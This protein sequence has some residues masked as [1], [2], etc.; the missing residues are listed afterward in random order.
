MVRRSLG[1]D[2][3]PALAPPGGTGV[4]TGQALLGA[5][6]A[7]PAVAT[8]LVAQRPVLL[9]PFGLTRRTGSAA[10]GGSGRLDLTDALLLDFDSLL[11]GGEGGLD[12]VEVLGAAVAAL[13]ERREQQPVNGP[14]QHQRHLRLE[15]VVRERT[16][17]VDEGLTTLL[18]LQLQFALLADLLA[19]CRQLLEDLLDDARPSVDPVPDE[20][21]EAAALER[22]DGPQAVQLL[23]EE[24]KDERIHRSHR[25]CDDAQLL[26]RTLERTEVVLTG[27][28]TLTACRAHHGDELRRHLGLVADGLQ[29]VDDLLKHRHALVDRVIAGGGGHGFLSPVIGWAPMARTNS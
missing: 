19:E 24:L 11:E 5:V 25:V 4:A 26:E 10:L 21:V 12:V 15:R 29:Q 16:K 17:P 20:D 13:V 1:R 6:A 23:T 14:G 18:K 8:H 9:G 3:V 7:G 2:A 22:H 28:L 27:V